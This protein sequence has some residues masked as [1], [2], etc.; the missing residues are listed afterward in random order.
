MNS[1]NK[2]DALFREGEHQKELKVNQDLKDRMSHELGTAKITSLK[3]YKY[4]GGVAAA[5]IVIAMILIGRPQD[6]N[7]ELEELTYDPH[8]VINTTTINLMPTLVDIV[9]KDGFLKG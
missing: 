1:E 4:I 3:V 6:T 5:L 7:Y 8:P 9:Y 2:I